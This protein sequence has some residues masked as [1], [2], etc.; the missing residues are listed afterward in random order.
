FDITY[1]KVVGD[2]KEGVHNNGS[3]FTFIFLFIS[4][5]NIYSR[6]LKHER[7]SDV[8]KL[9]ILILLRQKIKNQNPTFN[10][11]ILIHVNAL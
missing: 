10:L 11:Q 1:K 4:L 5:H 3:T 9:S 2:G 8:S 6:K 7:I